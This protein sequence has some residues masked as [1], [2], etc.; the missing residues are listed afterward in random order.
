MKPL[1]QTIHPS[2]LISLSLFMSI[3]TLKAQ[4][5]TRGIGIYPGDLKEDFSPIMKID[6]TTYRNLA[7]HRPAYQSS[8]YDFNL[9]A[10]LVTDGIIDSR[11][12]GWIGVTTSAEGNVKRNERE[13]VLDRNPMT[14][15]TIPGS[16][17]WLQVEMAGDYE[18][19]EIDSFDVEGSLLVDSLEA[20]QWEMVVSGSNDGTSWN[21]LG[22]VS[23]ERL[24][25]DT[26][27]GWMRRFYPQNMRAFIYPI[28]LNAAVYNKFYRLDLNSPNA[29]SW[30]IGEFG[31]YHDGKRAEIGGPYHF[32][33]A[34][35]SA[36]SGEEWV[37]VDLGTE[38]SFDR[39]GLYWIRRASAGSIQVSDDASSWKDIASLPNSSGDTEDVKFDKQVNGRYVRILMTKSASSDGY[40]LSELQVFGTGGPVPIAH[41]RAS[42]GK[43]KEKSLDLAGGAWKIQRASLVNSNGETISNPGFDD[44]DWLVA[45]VPATVLASYLN[46]GA[47]PDPNFG[48]NQFLVSDSYF[49]SDFWYRDMFPPP[50]P[51]RGDRYFLNFDGI[52]W[53]AE[54]YLNGKKLG[55]IEGAFTRAHFDVTDVL[56][57]EKEN[58]LA[59]RIIKNDKPGFVK[60]QTKLSHDANGGEL[61]ADDP[62]F[63]ASVGW[64]WIPTIR[65]RNT[66]IWNDVYLSVTG[67]V[68]IEDPYVSSDIP[69]PDTA[70]ADLNV[71]VTLHNYASARIKGKLLGKFGKMK[72]KEPIV[73]DPSET[74]TIKLDPSTNPSLRL[75]NPKLWWPNGYGEQNLY[76][77]Q[78]KFVTSDGRES[79]AK[80]FKTGIRK[81]TYSEDGGVLKYLGQWEKVCREGRQLG[82]FRIVASL[83]SA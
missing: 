35:K 63:H 21:K 66:G 82:F 79:D 50:I 11:P 58:V 24:P 73:L 18:V 19:P 46:A 39:I 49:Y 51:Y 23:G 68:T 76:D 3:F 65:G 41:E 1:A 14:R 74:K 22:T 56:V 15:L 64:D 60:E 37:Y 57:Y 80:S 9:T 47:L 40:I 45:T 28:K 20:K 54:V 26:L 83:S 53:K 67:P 62:T 44:K 6:N 34:W 16:R 30:S 81:L 25:G 31:M 33:S 8:C 29:E 78:L 36:G 4:D 69:L 17:V 5:Y 7:L 48:D 70:S 12:P 52:N 10:Q 71:G 38:C 32:T 43:N 59:V 27:T 2:I 55:R 13:W 61:G 72:F 75:K 42:V 77:V